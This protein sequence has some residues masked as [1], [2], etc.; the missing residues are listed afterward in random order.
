MRYIFYV[1]E[2]APDIKGDAGAKMTNV[3]EKI[4]YTISGEEY[5]QEIEK[6]QLG[7]DMAKHDYEH[8]QT[9]V[10]GAFPKQAELEA[11]EARLRSAGSHAGP[12]TWIRTDGPR[13]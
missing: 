10:S 11:A 13:I 6:R 5:R 9:Q 12:R 3:L 7:L 8:L 4:A 2:D 1:C